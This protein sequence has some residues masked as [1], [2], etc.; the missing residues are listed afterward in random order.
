MDP[1]IVPTEFVGELW[2]SRGPAPFH[3]ITVPEAV[4]LELRAVVRNAEGLAPG[5]TVTAGAGHPFVSVLKDLA[6][7]PRC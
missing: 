6:P 7:G 1:E 5:D 3:F 2:Y 4:C